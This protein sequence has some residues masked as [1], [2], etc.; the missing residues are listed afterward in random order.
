M[1][2]NNKSSKC[3]KCLSGDMIE[4]P[5]LVS[6][7]LTSLTEDKAK[8]AIEDQDADFVFR[9]TSCKNCGYSELYIVD[10]GVRKKRI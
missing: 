1:I 4:H 3:P 10:G 2:T 5:S 6:M 9:C 7:P 8:K